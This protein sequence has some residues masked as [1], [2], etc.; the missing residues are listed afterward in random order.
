MVQSGQLKS[1]HFCLSTAVEIL[2]FIWYYYYKKFR[3]DS[4]R[5]PPGDGGVIKCFDRH[6]F[7]IP[8]LEKNQE[9]FTSLL[10]LLAGGLSKMIEKVSEYCRN[11]LVFGLWLEY[12]IFCRGAVILTKVHS[13]FPCTS[14]ATRSQIYLLLYYFICA[15]ICLYLE[16]Q[17][18][19]QSFK[20]CLAFLG[21]EVN[22]YQRTNRT[23]ILPSV[24]RKYEPVIITIGMVV[25]LLIRQLV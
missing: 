20:S 23:C 22:K 24:Q 7:C 3:L 9:S 6:K 2:S 4:C 15:S 21:Q 12:Q 18:L 14:L 11:G 17:T 10:A 13:T 19:Q 16:G 25:D 8:D 1:E 5:W